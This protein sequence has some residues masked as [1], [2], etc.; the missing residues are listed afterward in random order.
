MA[1][2]QALITMAALFTAAEASQVM[3][4][5]SMRVR[6]GAEAFRSLSSTSSQASLKFQ[7]AFVNV[8]HRSTSN[9]MHSA[10]AVCG[11]WPSLRMLPNP[12]PLRLATGGGRLLSMKGASPSADIKEQPTGSESGSRKHFIS[13]MIQKDIEEGRHNKVVT[14]FPPEPNGY[15]HIGHAKSICLNFGVAKDF[16]GVTNMRFDDTNPVKEDQEYVDSIL[17]DVRWLV[18][19]DEKGPD[20]WDG[21]VRHASDYFDVFY[22][23]AVHLIKKGKAYVESLSAEEMREYRGSLT[24]PGKESPYRDRSVEENLEMFEKMKNG[25]YEEGQ[26]CLRAKIDMA[27]PNLNMRDPALYRVRKAEHVMTGNKWCIYPM[28]DFAHCIS[29]ALEEITHS[30]C[31]LEFEDHRPLYDWV[32]DELEDSDLITCHPRQ[33]EFSRLNLQYTVLS[34]RKLIQLVEGKHVAG[35]SDPRMPTISGVRRRGYTPEALRLFCERV[36]ISKADNNIDMS[37]LEDCARTTLEDTA[38]R[39]FAVLQPIKVTITNWPEGKV[40][41]FEAD[42]HPKKDMGKREIPFSG[43]VYIDSDDFSENPPKG[44][45][46]LTPGG[47]VRL[48]FAYVITCEEV[49]K[50]ADGKVVEIKATYNPDTRAGN[51]PEGMNKVKGIIQW[52]ST[53]T[54]VPCE[55]RVYDRL[56]TT[57]NPGSGHEDGDFLRDLNENSL[58][59]VKGAVEPS[60]LKMLDASHIQF[61]RVGY[62]CQDAEDSKPDAL[63]FNR[64]VTLRDNWSKQAEAQAPKAAKAEP[65]APADRNELEDVVRL[66]IRVGK[67]ISAEK[68]PD[69]DALY[70]EKID[71][72]DEEGPRTIVSGLAN[73]IPLEEMQG[74]MCTVL[75]NLKPAK[76]RG[77][78]SAGMV[79]CGSDNENG[80]VQLLEPPA[81]A[82]IG[83]RVTVEGYDEPTPDP[84]LKSKTQQKVWPRVAEDLKTD[85]EGRAV[86]KGKPL[87]TSAGGLSCADLKDVPI[88]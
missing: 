8:V 73:Y 71:V 74:R 33:T 20:P 67:I 18:S 30:L 35:W 72:G 83:E 46:R 2:R 48:K 22:D 50:D 34:K 15:L 10:A 84:V 55:V 54:A 37:V 53:E 21:N 4:K 45:F 61:E 17:T 82:K 13:N 41:M 60:V 26:H 49:I 6:G 56:F 70:I 63:V 11:Q 80:K 31:T 66:D 47:S 65:A 52:V 68:H 9:K 42:V 28:Y 57:E 81:G 40:E 77:V 75:C 64:V 24:T 85:A 44:F 29:D 27:S 14:R 69:A 3:L 38:A 5:S 39:A 58:Q 76:M 62:F 25:D 78:E 59:I 19:G 88:S 32:L 1:G 12:K 51:T 79:L 86:Y 16:K 36:G 7:D 23:A 87:L 43:S